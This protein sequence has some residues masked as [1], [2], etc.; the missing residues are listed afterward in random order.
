MPEAK[1]L[2]QFAMSLKVSAWLPLAIGNGTAADPVE[3]AGPKSDART[4]S[5]ARNLRGEL[6]KDGG[7]SVP[8]AAPAHRIC[9]GRTPREE[10]HRRRTGMAEGCAGS[11]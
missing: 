3:T 5:G 4:S 10:A 2:V 8:G 7:L 6:R 9:A 11:V 1:L